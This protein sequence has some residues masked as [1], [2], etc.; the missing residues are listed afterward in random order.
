M[1]LRIAIESVNQKK[2]KVITFRSDC[3]IRAFSRIVVDDLLVA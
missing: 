3:T 2:A 1:K